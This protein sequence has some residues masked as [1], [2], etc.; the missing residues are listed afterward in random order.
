MAFDLNYVRRI[1][2]VLAVGAT[3]FLTIPHLLVLPRGGLDDSWELALNIAAANRFQ[4]GK[5]LIFTFG[6]LGFF[7]LPFFFDMK[8]WLLSLGL[9]LF[10]HVMFFYSLILLMIKTKAE[11]R[12]YLLLCIALLISL[13]ITYIENKLFTTI[14]VLLYLA[15]TERF[16]ERFAPLVLILVSVL[17]AFGS[18]LKFTGLPI[19][20]SILLV[21]IVFFIRSGQVR[22]ILYV[23]SVYILSV[24]ALWIMAGQAVTNIPAY[25]S[26][27][28]EVA[29]GY[30]VAMSASGPFSRILL[31]VLIIGLLAWLL[32]VSRR[33]GKFNIIFF[34]L[35]NSGFILVSFK[36]GFVR[37]DDHAYFFFANMLVILSI[38]YISNRNE[39]VKLLRVLTLAVICILAVIISN[40]YAAQVT[41]NCTGRLSTVR[42]ALS[43]MTDISKQRETMEQCKNAI[44][45]SL[46]LSQD[47]LRQIHDVPV[48]IFPWEISLVY[49][50]DLRWSPRPVFQS[51]SAYTTKLDS[52]N[53]QHFRGIVAPR[54]LLFSL[55]SIDDRYPIFD[56]PETFRTLLKTYRPVSRDGEFIILEKKGTDDSSV[57]NNVLISNGSIG[58][59]I[60]VPKIA[61]GFLFARIHMNYNLLGKLSRLFF[62]PPLVYIHFIK[63]GNVSE[64][65]RFIP[66]NAKNGLFLS[67]RVRDLNDLYNVWEGRLTE[68]LDAIQI[69]AAASLFYKNNIKVEFFVVQRN[70]IKISESKGLQGCEIFEKLPRD[71]GKPVKVNY[72]NKVKLEGITVNKL[73][74]NQLKVSYHWRPLEDPGAYEQVFVHFTDAEDKGLFQN[75]HPFCQTTFKEI[76]GKILKETYTVDIPQA[77]VGKEVV[78]KVGIYSPEAKSNSRL[79]IE[80]P[81]TWAD[82][83]NTRASVAK[84]KL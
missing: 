64:R 80:S 18:L 78:V 26:N 34:I 22:S 47:T 68:N 72:G 63:N 19:S 39:I 35:I 74:S 36:H 4:S 59:P 30:D 49:A 58:K 67:E 5:D 8:L 10:V 56:E 24:L 71:I 12:H 32:L 44:R 54:F 70:V 17:M 50:Y 28:Y 43:V 2:I 25:L 75:D 1:I 42:H 9:H 69:S 33:E 29:R 57:E 84:V 41:P 77:A 27:S 15:I 76:K 83:F 79:K 20:L 13:P 62:R 37:H 46:P 65:Y 3:S 23:S 21:L 11:L 53:A 40:K 52:L 51:Y 38:L 82:D 60:S 61:N 55:H 45:E 16:D 6:P 31:G 48:D 81:G 66:S 14:L 73:S 7:N